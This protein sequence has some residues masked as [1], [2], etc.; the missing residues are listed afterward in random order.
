MAANTC[1]EGLRYVWP[2]EE[3]DREGWHNHQARHHQ[4]Y[5]EEKVRLSFLLD[6]YSIAWVA[7]GFRQDVYRLGLY[8]VAIILNHD[9]YGTNHSRIHVLFITIMP[10]PS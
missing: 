10:I 7:F 4:D 5:I 3:G 8:R 2:L 9:T 1:F 6:L